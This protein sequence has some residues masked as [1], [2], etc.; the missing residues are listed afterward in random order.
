MESECAK[1]LR[2]LGEAIRQARKRLDVSQEDFAELC[3][4][5]WAYIGQV[6]RGEKN[7]SFV[8]IVRISSALRSEPSALFASAGL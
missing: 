6:E 5:H 8:N 4:L 7:I 3:G 1:E 2:L